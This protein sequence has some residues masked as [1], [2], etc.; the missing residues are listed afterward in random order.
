VKFEFDK[1]FLLDPT[2]LA[3]AGLELPADV[4]R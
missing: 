3:Q 2:Y 1:I 4:E